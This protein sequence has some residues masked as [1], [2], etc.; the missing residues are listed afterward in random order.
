[1]VSPAGGVG[2]RD[3]AVRSKARCM[4]RRLG[5]PVLGAHMQAVMVPVSVCMRV[6][7]TPK[8]EE[9]DPCCRTTA[10]QAS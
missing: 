9:C 6:M 8:D 2:I 7:C 5:C 3:S 4:R 10:C 1:M